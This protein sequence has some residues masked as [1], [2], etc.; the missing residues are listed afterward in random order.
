MIPIHRLLRLDDSRSVETSRNVVLLPTLPDQEHLTDFANTVLRGVWTSCGFAPDS[1]SRLTINYEVLLCANVWDLSR[2]AL[3]I[4]STLN[5]AV[6]AL[7]FRSSDA[8][9][10]EERLTHSDIHLRARILVTVFNRI[11]NEHPKCFIAATSCAEDGEQQERCPCWQY[12]AV[13]RHFIGG[14]DNSGSELGPYS[15][16]WGRQ[17]ESHYE[18]QRQQ[19]Q[20]QQ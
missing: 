15:K 12:R 8:Y 6:S 9:A 18:Q 19:Q 17:E 13:I 10:V 2:V 3:L 4:G 20:Q 14:C 5:A 16:W 11:V 7:A 1:L